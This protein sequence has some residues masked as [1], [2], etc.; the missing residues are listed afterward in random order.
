[1]EILH[2]SDLHLSQEARSKGVTL[3]RMWQHARRELPSYHYKFDFVVLSGDL[4]QSAQPAEYAMLEELLGVLV[5]EHLVENDKRRIVL[6]PGNHDV[7][8]GASYREPVTTSMIDADDALKQ[9]LV[10]YLKNGDGT[11]V[12]AT[13]SSKGPLGVE[14]VWR[15][16]DTYPERFRECQGFLNRFYTDAFPCDPN[17]RC[18]DLLSTDARQH[19]SAHVF[20]AQRMVIYGFNS[21]HRNDASWIGAEICLDAVDAAVEHAHRLAPCQND[22]NEWTRIVVWHHGLRS[23]RGRPDHLTH[24]ELENLARLSPTL[25][26]H[27][28]TH[29]NALEDLRQSLRYPFP[30]LATGSFAIDPKGKPDTVAN[31]YSVISLN[32]A[33]IRRQ[34]YTKT[35]LEAWTREVPSLAD[36]V[37]RKFTAELPPDFELGRI[38]RHA[39]RVVVDRQGIATV[40]VRLEEVALE[41]N[42]TLAKE[43]LLF[44]NVAADPDPTDSV[45]A[46]VKQSLSL[47]GSVEFVLPWSGSRR[48]ASVDFDYRITN[49]FASRAE[50]LALFDTRK[51]DKGSQVHGAL[52][53]DVIAQCDRLSLE[54][55]L[56]DATIMRA[57]ARAERRSKTHSTGWEVD[58]LET[59]RIEPE[60]ITGDTRVARLEVTEPTPG[61]RYVLSYELKDTG[62]SIREK[63]QLVL[64]E[65][66]DS[67]YRDRGT[68]GL[69]STLSDK[70]G[71]EIHELLGSKSGGVGPITWVA[72]VWDQRERR[73]VPCFG[74]FA[75]HEWRTRFAFGEGVIGHGF[76]RNGSAMYY[77]EQGSRI[78]RTQNNALIYQ[79]AAAA[80]A[81]GGWLQDHAWIF[82]VPI[83]LGRV[84][85]AV[86]M[87]GF[88]GRESAGSGH[89]HYLAR[90]A[91]IATRQ[92]RRA[93]SDLDPELLDATNVLERAATYWFWRTLAQHKDITHF[94]QLTAREVVAEL[95]P[96]PIEEHEGSEPSAFGAEP[97]SG[98]R[99]RRT[100]PRTAD[101]C[102]RIRAFVRCGRHTEYQTTVLDRSAGSLLGGMKLFGSC[103]DCVRARETVELVVDGQ[104]WIAKVRHIAESTLSSTFGVEL[105]PA[106]PAWRES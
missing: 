95:K 13:L 102:E 32:C 2:L 58:S 10:E 21:C 90:L 83:L 84:G 54:I 97:G 98:T 9:K 59:L 96:P 62:R 14:E 22:W 100:R 41:G 87:I 29:K 5:E 26:L 28:H 91:D 106:A 12:R 72:Y 57:R 61:L 40:Q 55:E 76:K 60:P 69:R 34:L 105:T 78:E 35:E 47:D 16:G 39:R 17:D 51:L 103:C 104:P 70:I 42:L 7:N 46:D 24:S 50:D 33:L 49:A 63:F 45:I 1:M 73:L 77:S 94:R 31:Q 81:T 18:L 52:V 71:K 89:P 93:E 85:P 4:T 15:L 80:Q 36:C 99:N 20:S 65:A 27:G 92:D 101:G 38:G 23:E 53:H 88:A 48:L 67:C 68:E 66:I 64:E 43:L 6:V 11:D 44:S 19:F 75:P 79:S 25:A 37:L 56:P 3:A 8:W 82:S 30:I 86:G 74:E